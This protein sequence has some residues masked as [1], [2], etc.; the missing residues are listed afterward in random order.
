MQSAPVEALWQLPQLSM[1]IR[2]TH[3]L[4]IIIYIIEFISF[5]SKT[6][7]EESNIVTNL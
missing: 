1:A 2:I 5:K 6:S 4:L 3:I 7:G